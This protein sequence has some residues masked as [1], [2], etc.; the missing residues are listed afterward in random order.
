MTHLL[1]LGEQL[2]RMKGSQQCGG[3]WLALSPKAGPGF[4]VSHLA[5]RPQLVPGW[6]QACGRLGGVTWGLGWPL[7]TSGTIGREGAVPLLVDNPKQSESVYHLPRG[8][9]RGAGRADLQVLRLHHN[10]R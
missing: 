2:N 8:G 1:G 6:G 5:G 3:G 7:L 10:H 4:G 9:P